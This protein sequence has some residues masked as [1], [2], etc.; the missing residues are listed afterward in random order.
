MR[1]TGAEA[2]P[3]QVTMMK[4]GEMAKSSSASPVTSGV[5]G[6][7]PSGSLFG[8]KTFGAPTFSFN[9]SNANKTPSLFKPFSTTN[10]S[11]ALFGSSTTSVAGPL[12]APTAPSSFTFGNTL[13]SSVSGTLFGGSASKLFGR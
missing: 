13:N 9:T 6:F 11:P 1:F 4:I 10:T 7:N 8:S 3:S 2:F 12:P 5:S